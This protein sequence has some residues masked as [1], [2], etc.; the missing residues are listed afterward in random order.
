M[1]YDL[2]WIH[3]RDVRNRS[4]PPS[5]LSSNRSYC[6]NQP[7]TDRGYTI[8]WIQRFSFDHVPVNMYCSKIVY[9]KR[10]PDGQLDAPEATEFSSNSIDG[11]IRINDTF[12]V[13]DLSELEPHSGF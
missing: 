2:N 4:L 3:I 1:C 6:T 8:N 11:H 10:L 13:S 12:V 5:I 7:Y 9:I